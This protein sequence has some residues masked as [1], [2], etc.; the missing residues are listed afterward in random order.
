MTLGELLPDYYTRDE[1][2]EIVENAF[3]VDVE[4]ITRIEITANNITFRQRVG[5]GEKVV[6]IPVVDV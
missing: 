6:Q 4:D 5:A 2:N 1:M 3:P